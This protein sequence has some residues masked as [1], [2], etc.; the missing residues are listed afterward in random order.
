M[1]AW[2]Q[3]KLGTLVWAHLWVTGGSLSASSTHTKKQNGTKN[4]LHSRKCTFWGCHRARIV[5]TLLLR[6]YVAESLI[7]IVLHDALLERFGLLV[8]MCKDRKNEG[9]PKVGSWLDPPK[10]IAYFQWTTATSVL[11]VWTSGLDRFVAFDL[12]YIVNFRNSIK[13]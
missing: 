12:N 4:K 13:T 1:L 11:R 2:S 10:K 5:P 7:R 6:K 9:S 8:A 3:I